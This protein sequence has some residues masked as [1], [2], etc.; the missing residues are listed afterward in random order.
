M[1]NVPSLEVGHPM[2]KIYVGKVIVHIAVGESGERL[3]NAARI[4]ESLTGQKPSLRKA[5]KS[6]KEFGIRR[7]EN[8]ACMVTLRGERAYDFLKRA[9][10][11]VNNTIQKSSID[12]SGNFAFGIKEH[13]LIPGTKY[14]PSLGIFGMDVIVRLERPGYR[15]SR[16]RRKRAN[17]GKKHYVTRDEAVE[18]IKKVLG[19]RVV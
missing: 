16:R 19:A 3:A 13:L 18:F 1:P 14:D 6:I 17:I 8:I 2:R 9:L 4:L 12:N 7:G 11:A 15:V 10:A 5:K